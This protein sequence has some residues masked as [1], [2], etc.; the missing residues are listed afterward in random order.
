MAGFKSGHSH[1]VLAVVE[2]PKTWMAGTEAGH[3]AN[4]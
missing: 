1:V 4:Y 3:H 2:V